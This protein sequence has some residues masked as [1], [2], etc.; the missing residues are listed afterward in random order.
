MTVEPTFLYTGG[1]CEVIPNWDID[2]ISSIDVSNIVTKHLGYG[3]YKTVWYMSVNGLKPLN[4]DADILCF[5][6][7]VKGHGV[8][9]VY[10]EHNSEGEKQ[11]E[12]EQ[13]SDVEI[14][15]ITEEIDEVRVDEVRVDEVR[16]DEFITEN[17]VEE[18]DRII[19]QVL[20]SNEVRDQQ[21]NGENAVG[22]SEERVEEVNVE[23]GVAGSEEK[24]EEVNAEKGDSDSGDEEFKPTEN[25]SDTDSDYSFDDSD[26]E[27][28][29]D[30]LSVLPAESLLN[31]PQE[32]GF[33]PSV[34]EGAPPNL[35]NPS[36]FS[37]FDDEDGYSEDYDNPDGS[38]GEE[39]SK[40]NFPMF[41]Q[42]LEGELV[43]FKKG[44]VFKSKAQF[45]AAVRDYALEQRKNLK[46]VKND[47]VR[48]LVQCVE[49]CPC[50]MRIT[51][52]KSRPYFQLVGFNPEHTC[53][54][55]ARNRQ[56]TTSW[57]GRKLMPVLRHVPNMK[58]AGTI[59]EVRARW[60]I[61]ID[62]DK[63]YRVRV[64]AS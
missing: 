26:Y 16:V 36:K 46:F 32:P 13:F 35:S 5:L 42:P 25:E 45:I 10:V 38:D 44:Q 1:S 55:T 3:S 34:L 54:R 4:C 11:K 2:E 7:D 31:L 14:V 24:V 39:S 52:T 8:V 53:C 58:R 21:V 57:L 19:D 28:N 9:D 51:K 50:Y 47:K 27:E 60:G 62:K 30:W 41:R 18:I 48:V 12:K 6:A 59:D 17:D 23:N 61:L 64:A 15:E 43:H 29:Y 22:G 49:G 56:A 63:A 33:A 40:K 20:S 37:D